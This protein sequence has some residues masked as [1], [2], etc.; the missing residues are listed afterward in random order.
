M[1]KYPNVGQL[2]GPYSNVL[3]AVDLKN[4]FIRNWLDM[5]CFLLSGLPADG[6]ITAEVWSSAS[7]MIVRTLFLCPHI[8]QIRLYAIYWM[9]NDSC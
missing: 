2:I 8:R 6:T 3:D 1:L 9:R 7:V 5:L 4:K